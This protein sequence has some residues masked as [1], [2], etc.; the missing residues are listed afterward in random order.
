MPTEAVKNRK[1]REI[2]HGATRFEIPFFQRGYAWEKKQWDQLFLDIREQILC[3]IQ[4]GS[5]PEDVEHFFGPIVVQEKSGSEQLKEYLVIDGQQRLTT[6][7][8]LL[9][10]ISDSIHAKRHLSD[11]ASGRVAEMK[12]YLVN[13]VIGGDD[14]LKLKIFSSKGDRLPTYRVVFGSE[15]NPRT[16]LLH[17]DQQL[18]LP[19]RN[20]VEDFQKYAMKRL[21]SE[22]PDVPSLI[23]LSVAILDCLTI[24]W[25]PLDAQK[26][27]PQAIFESLNDKG[28]PLKASELLCNYLF[29]PIIASNLPFEDLHNDKWLGATHLLQSNEQF[30]ECLRNLFSIGENKMVGKNRKVYIHFKNKNRSLTTGAAQQ[31]LHDIYDAT[32]LYRSIVNPAASPHGDDSIH[33][34]LINISNTRMESSIPFVL[35]VLQAQ[36]ND[37][38]DIC[39]ARTI[40]RE[41]LVLLVRRKMT[42]QST[43]QYDTMFPGLLARIVNET[44]PI[45]ALHDQFQKNKVWVSDQ[46]FVEALISRPLYRPRDISFTKMVL[47][48]LDKQ[49][50][51]FGQLPDYTTVGTIEHTLPQTPGEDWLEYIGDDRY[52]ARLQIVTQTVG[53]LCLLSGPANSSAGRTPFERK[54]A[55]YSHVTAL[56]RSIKD[57]TGTWNIEGIQTRS[58]Q[59]AEKATSIWA[60]SPD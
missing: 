18:Y 59:L 44:R 1:F 58:R 55:G 51:D 7:Y 36:A 24:V 43:T 25:I 39:L 32:R 15:A 27:D 35:S 21:R 23:E 11:A 60:W 20:R 52:D 19:G 29:R 26:D 28:M 13:D 30:E 33:R 40:L 41:T 14:Y 6:I 37:R 12:R 57:F 45:A 5:T 38:L 47:V 46:D 50:Q 4:A 16:P 8:L 53:N 49:Y 17:T 3:D 34:T 22:F 42:E 31:H 54:A 56:A 9:C 10:V 2:F 48:E